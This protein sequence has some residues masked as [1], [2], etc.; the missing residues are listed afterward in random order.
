MEK[1]SLNAKLFSVQEVHTAGE[2]N[3]EG[4]FKQIAKPTFRKPTKK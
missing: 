1:Q 3:R 4:V 2:V